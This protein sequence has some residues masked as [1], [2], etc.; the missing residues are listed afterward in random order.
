MRCSALVDISDDTDAVLISV[1]IIDIV[2]VV[3]ICVRVAYVDVLVLFFV[4]V[5]FV[6]SSVVPLLGLYAG[7]RSREFWSVL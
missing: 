7:R 5:V 6:S 1:L 3:C 4:L 2:L